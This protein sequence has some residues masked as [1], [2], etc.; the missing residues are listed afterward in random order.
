MELWAAYAVVINVHYILIMLAKV[1]FQYLIPNKSYNKS[2]DLKNPIAIST[3]KAHG[4][5]Y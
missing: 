5:L 1:S 2:C 3:L 4:A